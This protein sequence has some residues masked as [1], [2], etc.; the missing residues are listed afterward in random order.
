MKRAELSKFRALARNQG[1]R[2]KFQKFSK[3]LTRHQCHQAIIDGH[4]RPATSDGPCPSCAIRKQRPTKHHQRLNGVPSANITC[5]A[6]A[7][8]W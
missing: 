3:A 8:A 7:A 5:F 6:K 1:R 2:W 4:R